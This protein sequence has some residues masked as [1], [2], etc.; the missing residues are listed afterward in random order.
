[1]KL[2]VIAG[3]SSGDQL[4]RDLVEAIRGRGIAVDLVGVVVRRCRASG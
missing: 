4:G 2:A 1:M 3:E